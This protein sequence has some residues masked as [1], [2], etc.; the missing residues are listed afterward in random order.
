M[1]GGCRANP[2]V[3]RR[4]GNIDGY[5]IGQEAQLAR[6]ALEQ[7]SAAVFELKP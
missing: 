5:R 6:H 4:P 1:A 3:A 7:V 2:D